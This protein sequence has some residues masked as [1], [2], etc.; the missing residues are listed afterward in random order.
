MEYVKPQIIC[1]DDAVVAIQSTSKST[2]MT[3]DSKNVPFLVTISAY[4]ADE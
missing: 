3:P 1:L 4:E 2:S